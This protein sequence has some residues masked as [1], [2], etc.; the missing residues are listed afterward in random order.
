MR[1]LQPALVTTL[2]AGMLAAPAIAAEEDTTPDLLPG[3]DLVT[4][5]VEPGVYRVLSDGVRDLTRQVQDVAVTPTGDVWVEQGTSRDWD[6]IRLGEPDVSR[7]L[8]REKPWDLFTLDGTPT[9]AVPV[10][11]PPPTP[12]RT[13]DGEGWV[14][15]EPTGCDYWQRWGQAG[16]TADGQCW[17]QLPYERG[18]YPI[19]DSGDA[20]RDDSGEARPV[21]LDAVGS[22]LDRF[23]SSVD[24][25]D[26]GT[27]WATVHSSETSDFEGLVR[28]D[29]E[30]W[31]FTPYDAA[32]EP[33]VGNRRRD[34]WSHIALG[35]DGRVWAVDIY[36]PVYAAGNKSAFVVRVW[37]GE[38]WM[39]LGPVEAPQRFGSP[40]TDARFL[41]D[42]SVW[43]LDGWLVVDDDG[44][45]TQDLP[46]VP[47]NVE[48]A[49]DGSAWTVI[50]RQLYVVTP[51]AVMVAE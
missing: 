45:R 47:G 40:R 24:V 12:W 4:E 32:L 50:D 33:E 17:A 10:F 22:T 39:T 36:H 6:I 5:E 43:L 46:G 25:T 21:V 30:T 18:V 35:P 31:E 34:E 29:G 49:P 15:H 48:F 2:A 38:D 8:G 51:E 28:Y 19:D 16:I 3:V 14:D 42:G 27:L 23:M 7:T 37:D 1:S 13:F 20:P 9:V 41:D 11:G 44:L 26:D